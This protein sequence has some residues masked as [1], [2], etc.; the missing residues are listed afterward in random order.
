MYVISDKGRIVTY[1]KNPVYL[2]Y[3]RTHLKDMCSKRTA[4]STTIVCPKCHCVTSLF[5][6]CYDNKVVI[7]K[8]KYHTMTQND[9]KKKKCDSVIEKQD[10]LKQFIE[11]IENPKNISFPEVVA[12]QGSIPHLHALH[13]MIGQPNLKNELVSFC[14]YLS[15]ISS[16]TSD[17]RLNVCLYGGPGTGKSTMARVIAELFV[18]VGLLPK[19]CFNSEEKFIVG[20]RANM[21]GQFS[22]HTAP[23]TQ[24]LIDRCIIEGKVLLLDEGYQFCLSSE[25]DTFG[26][27]MIN[28]LNQNL[29]ENAGKLFVIL[30]GYESNI[31]KSFF[32]VNKGLRRRFDHHYRIEAYNAHHLSQMMEQKLLANAFDVSEIMTESVSWFENKKEMFPYVGGDIESLVIKI[33]IAH[34]ERVFCLQNTTPQKIT[35]ADLDI[36]MIKF[37][38]TRTPTEDTFGHLEMYA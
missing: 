30:A 14:K 2:Y 32:D 27:E 13:S 15:Q 1:S 29:T 26:E 24:A 38:K 3:R 4:P 16:H 8:R 33:K 25:K 20:T 11:F 35:Q 5:G 23:R 21:I 6:M 18:G 37:E 28:T 22:G 9:G 31:K 34:A 12:L 7:M 36:A 17:D 19:T 10:L